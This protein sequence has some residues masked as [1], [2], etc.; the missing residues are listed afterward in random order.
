MKKKEFLEQ[1][2]EEMHQVVITTLDEVKKPSTNLVA[3]V[4]YENTIGF[5]V[6]KESELYKQVLEQGYV[7]LLGYNE[8]KVVQM[9]GNVLLDEYEKNIF[10]IV[11]GEGRYLEKTYS[12]QMIDE[13]FTL[14]KEE[15]PDGG[16]YVTDACI[17]CGT[18]YA[19]CSKQCIDTAK[20]PV[21][22]NQ[23]ECIQCGECMQVCPV[24]AI[25]RK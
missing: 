14:G 9:N 21:V 7:S 11:E 3:L 25:M 24:Q 2:T 17:L 5:V 6:E 23:K 13:T 8:N 16:Y 4:A 10:Y 18:C 1:I 15:I 22:I 12:E 19:V 20:D